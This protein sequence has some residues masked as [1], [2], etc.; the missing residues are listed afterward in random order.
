MEAEYIPTKHGAVIQA[1]SLGEIQEF[2]KKLCEDF[3]DNRLKFSNYDEKPDG[4]CIAIYNTDS[5][6]VRG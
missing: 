5:S 6:R 1:D 3:P 4:K 2:W